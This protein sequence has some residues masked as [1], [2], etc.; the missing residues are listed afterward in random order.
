MR[1][2][3]KFIAFPLLDEG[4]EFGDLLS[5]PLFILWVRKKDT[6][7]NERLVEERENAIKLFRDVFIFPQKHITLWLLKHLLL[8]IKKTYF[9]E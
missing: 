1:T 8:I 9:I 7:L 4:E 5:V 2:E 3:V 6:D